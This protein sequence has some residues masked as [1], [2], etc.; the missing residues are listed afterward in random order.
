MLA[1][2]KIKLI[3]NLRPLYNEYRVAFA[4]SCCERLVPN[5][6]A[7]C[8]IEN[9][10]NPEVLYGALEKVW[11]YVEGGSLSKEDIDS[12]I[13][14][15]KEIIPDTEDFY[16]I[17]TELA[18]NSVAA[19]IY[20]LR[21]II[22]TDL[23]ELANV[24]GLAVESVESYLSAVNDPKIGVHSA[25]KAF[26]TWLKRAPLLVS[27]LNKQQED[28]QFLESWMGERKELIQILRQSSKTRGIQPFA[29]G[30]FKET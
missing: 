10:G 14:S 16:S 11:V 7:F 22:E 24:G 23:D 8:I 12:L 27:E 13:L 2:N 26:D 28:I 3:K 9:W 17:F 29:R 30:I 19:I 1:F 4:A 25:D 5:Y 6:N 18:V 20:T 21:S 15:C